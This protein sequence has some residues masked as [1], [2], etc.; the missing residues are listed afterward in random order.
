M[1]NQHEIALRHLAEDAMPQ[2]IFAYCLLFVSLSIWAALLLFLFSL[3]VTGIVPN[4]VLLSAGKLFFSKRIGMFLLMGPVAIGW[5]CYNFSRALLNY[6]K[7]PNLM[8]ASDKFVLYLRSFRSDEVDPLVDW[9]LLSRKWETREERLAN[10][11]GPLGPLIAVGRPSEVI[12][13]LGGYRVYF[14][15]K[16][17][18]D[19]VKAL[20]KSAMFVFLNGSG[21]EVSYEKLILSVDERGRPNNPA[22]FNHHWDN[23]A[24]PFFDFRAT[25]WEVEYVVSNLPPEKLCLLL[26]RTTAEY[27]AFRKAAGKL[28]PKELPEPAEVGLEE[29]FGADQTEIY[30]IRFNEEWTPSKATSVASFVVSESSST[31]QTDY[32]QKGQ[33]DL[34]SP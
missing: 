24:E 18:Q 1:L 2:R 15:N 19:G 27:V 12:P 26:P 13:S 16:E 9:G 14:S 3:T 23:P 10:H 17:W 22:H 31:N 28:F 33:S 5:Y 8:P 21:V 20:A 11:I 34:S 7:H 32:S 29:P 6:L 4:T 25:L 30:L